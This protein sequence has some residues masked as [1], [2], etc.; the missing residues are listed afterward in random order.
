MAAPKLKLI[1]SQ[2][3]IEHIS[4]RVR[5]GINQ[6]TPECQFKCVPSFQA[7]L[8]GPQTIWKC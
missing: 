3:L 1:L 5:E 6:D 8:E 7:G 4:S 2:L